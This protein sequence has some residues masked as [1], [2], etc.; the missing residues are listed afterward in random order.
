MI[1]KANI[2]DANGIN[3][4][5]YQ[6]QD[7]HASKRSDIFIKNAKK[8]KDEELLEILKND[9]FIFY[10]FEENNEILGY[11]CITIIINEES[12]SKKQRKELFIEDLCVDESHHR[13]HIGSKLFA[14][15]E[16]IAKENN[17]DC[18][19]LNVWNFN[20]SALAF[21]EKM[22]MKALKTKLEKNI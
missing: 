5:L 1:R 9:E 2:D 14:Y 4:L 20:E 17:C 7:I 11:I 22:G 12:F 18:V 8:F 13:L 3:K 21:Y 19:T 10:I 16:D 6:V 15:A